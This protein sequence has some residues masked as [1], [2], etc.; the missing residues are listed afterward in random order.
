MSARLL[1]GLIAAA[2]IAILCFG[3]IG[4]SPPLLRA[5]ESKRTTSPT[6]PGT[7]D[8]TVF[9]A[10]HCV[11]C[12]AGNEPAGGLDLELKT[13]ELSDAEQRR[14]WTYLHDRVSQG[15]MPPAA[16]E[17]PAAQ[18]KAKSLSS[19]GQSLTLADL[20]D[21]E[22]VL[23]RLNRNEYTNTVSDL[24]G[25]HVDL[26]RLLVDDSVEN[27][28]DNTGSKLSVS[29]EQLEIYVEAA[30]LLLDQVF[31]TGKKTKP[32]NKSMNFSTNSRG[33]GASERMLADGVILF[34][35][36]KA[37]PLYALS[38]PT[39]GLYRVRVEVHAEQSKTPVIMKINGGNTGRIAAHT[40]GFFEVP[41]GKNTTIVFTDRSLERYDTFSIGLVGGYPYWSVN[42]K[43]YT[44]PGLF[45][46]DISIEGPIEEWPPSIL[47]SSV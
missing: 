37:L 40:V 39:P 23:R 28:F 41:P 44:G 32:V 29:A 20:K 34:S 3:R 2:L 27:G 10:T 36:A 19:L 4:I 33:T 38:A 5:D 25:I 17:Q 35:G 6:P 15:E 21:R 42:S 30:D 46:G 8:L 16:A 7:A 13:V 43:T 24:F 47:K 9:F 22:V 31:G 45:I 1:C 18:A 26:S 14:R 11:S 12:H